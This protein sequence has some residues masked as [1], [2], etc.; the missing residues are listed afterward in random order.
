M[1]P[2]ARSNRSVAPRA[3]AWIETSSLQV[4]QSVCTVAPPARGRGLK[5]N[6]AK[7]LGTGEEVA[8]RVGAWIE[9]LESLDTEAGGTG[10]PSRG[11]VD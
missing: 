4:T 9:T 10:R 3:G 8:P 1:S 7:V 11:G 2:S 5:L 6:H